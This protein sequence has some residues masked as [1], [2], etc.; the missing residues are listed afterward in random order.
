MEERRLGPVVGLGTWNKFDGDVRLAREVVTAAL[1]AGSRVFDS[2]P[3]YGAAE[4][5]L[6]AA[7]AE[8][9]ASSWSVSPSRDLSDHAL[10]GRPRATHR[11]EPTADAVTGVPREG[12]E[13]EPK[14]M[15]RRF[16]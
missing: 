5:S 7:L 1:H 11:F 3:L 15:L 6:A 2:S 13:S 14:V 12:A 16:E 4:A 9:S 10:R 8:R